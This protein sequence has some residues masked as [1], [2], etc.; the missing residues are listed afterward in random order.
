LQEL[1]DQDLQDIANWEAQ[2]Y[3]PPSIVQ[4]R[5]R[6]REFTSYSKGRGRLRRNPT[7]IALIQDTYV[8]IRWMR[9]SNFPFDTKAQE[10][11]QVYEYDLD[12]LEAEVR[13]MKEIK[14]C[15]R[16]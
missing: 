1:T 8:S 16:N 7:E 6:F 14:T 11:Y 15:Q 12:G 10:V 13:L 4:Q 2:E 5:F 9:W 3:I